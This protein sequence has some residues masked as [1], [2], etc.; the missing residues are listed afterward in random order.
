MSSNIDTSS[1]EDDRK[2]NTVYSFQ[3]QTKLERL[4][5]EAAMNNAVQAMRQ[6]HI[7][8]LYRASRTLILELSALT[9]GNLEFSAKSAV[10]K[11][12]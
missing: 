4:R 6:E 10:Q 3:S 8:T 5:Q 7:K 1:F 9:F 2:G 12:V 11:H